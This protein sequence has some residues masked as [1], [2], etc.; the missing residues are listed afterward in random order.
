M[1]RNTIWPNSVWKRILE[2]WA[3]PLHGGAGKQRRLDPVLFTPK[4][5][6]KPTGARCL[7]LYIVCCVVGLCPLHGWERS[8]AYLRSTGCWEEILGRKYLKKH[9]Q[10]PL[11][12]C[13]PKSR[14]MMHTDVPIDVIHF[15]DCN[16]KF[17]CVKTKEVVIWIYL[18]SAFSC[19]LYVTWVQ[20]LT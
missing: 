13:P 12:L 2:I 11:S 1:A 4:P 16:C 14:S 6:P 19:S 3:F 8:A 18:R 7:F 5:K 10:S 15:N 20:P 9:K 17:G